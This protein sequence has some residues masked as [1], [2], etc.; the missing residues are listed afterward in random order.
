MFLKDLNIKNFR[1]F[2]HIDLSFDSSKILI[3]GENG[4]GKTSILEAIYYLCYLKSFRT[5][6]AKEMINTGTDNLFVKAN[7]CSNQNEDNIIQAGLSG[8]KKLVKV[9]NKSIGTYKE[10]IK[11]YRVIA[12]TDD[13]L[14]L[15][16]DGPE[17]RRNFID[18]HIILNNP[19]L[20]PQIRK[21]RHI[22]DS[23][24][25]MLNKPNSDYESYLIWSRQL[26]NQSIIICQER[27]NALVILQDIVNDLF[28]QYFLEN[29][30]TEFRYDSKQSINQFND[31]DEFLCKN[32]NFYELERQNKRSLFGVHLDDFN[33]LFMQKKSRIFASR[34]QQKLLVLLIKIAQIKNLMALNGQDKALLMLLDDFMTDFDSKRLEILMPMLYSL[35]AQLIFTTPVE[36]SSLKRILLEQNPHL[37]RLQNRIWR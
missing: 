31:F 33:I 29:L 26:W 34:G 18:Q 25:A 12:L 28:S 19:E 17:I 13:D 5:H 36:D 6:I 23:R 4:S 2:D 30:R 3:E 1:C 27:I 10:L 15:I 22:L 20:L 21:Y 37:I 7:F 24:N 14:G 16:Q 8:K 32:P 11:H 9:N 35:N